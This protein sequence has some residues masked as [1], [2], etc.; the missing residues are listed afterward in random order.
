[1]QIKHKKLLA[2]ATGAVIGAGASGLL[3]FLTSKNKLNNARRSI[4][5]E[6][7]YDLMDEQLPFSTP[8]NEY[9]GI[10]HYHERLR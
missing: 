1:M 9:K 8:F 4:D 3:Y 7:A 2:V 5:D 10:E 6:L